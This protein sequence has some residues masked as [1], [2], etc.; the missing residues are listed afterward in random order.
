MLKNMQPLSCLF[1]RY[2]AY[3]TKDTAPLSPLSSFNNNKVSQYSSCSYSI[4]C[5]D[6]MHK[7]NIQ[8]Y[9]EIGYTTRMLPLT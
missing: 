4:Q 7:N 1:A 9:P 2:E 6:F 8:G 5:G 3:V